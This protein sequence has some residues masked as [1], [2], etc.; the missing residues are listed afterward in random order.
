MILCKKDSS[1]QVNVYL[2]KIIN[3]ITLININHKNSHNN[4]PV[5]L[6][7]IGGASEFICDLKSVQI[8]S[9]LHVI[10]ILQKK[11]GKI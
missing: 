8:G 9:A 11:Y 3:V 6:I 1:I 7:T 4:L 5:E 10:K 2:I